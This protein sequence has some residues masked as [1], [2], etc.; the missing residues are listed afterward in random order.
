MKGRQ[1]QDLVRTAHGLA[2]LATAVVRPE[3]EFSPAS[4]IEAGKKKLIVPVLV[5]PEPAIRASAEAAKLDLAL[6]ACLSARKK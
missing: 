2:P 4:A 6:S 3:E 1:H 5:S